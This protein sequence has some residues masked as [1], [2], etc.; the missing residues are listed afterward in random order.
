MFQ[1]TIDRVVL[2]GED[3]VEQVTLK[4]GRNTLLLK[5]LNRAGHWHATVSLSNSEGGQVSGIQFTP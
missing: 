1:S 4:Q 2:P 3:S 5:I